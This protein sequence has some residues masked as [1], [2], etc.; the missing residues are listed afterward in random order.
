[1][2]PY[3]YDGAGSDDKGMNEFFGESKGHSFDN[4]DWPEILKKYQESNEDENK[5]KDKKIMNTNKHAMAILIEQLQRMNAY[6]KP[7]EKINLSIKNGLIKNLQ[8][9]YLIDDLKD[10]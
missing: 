8:S 1:M 6:K 7:N 9:T 5:K 4:L 2:N 3:L 10:K